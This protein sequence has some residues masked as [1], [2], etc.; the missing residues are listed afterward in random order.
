MAVERLAG[1]NQLTDAEKIGEVSR[2]FE[3]I[4]L[5]QF[6]GNGFQGFEESSLQ[7]R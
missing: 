3:S 5:R 4:L 2:H 6:L 7:S 1:N